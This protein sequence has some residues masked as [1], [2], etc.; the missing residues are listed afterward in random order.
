VS[1]VEDL[2][3]KE[4]QGWHLTGCIGSGADGIVY[5]GRKEGTEAAVKIFFPESLAKNGLA[6]ARERLELQLALIGKKHHPNLVE[7]FEG[8]EFQALGTL[9]L[10]M[11]LVPG[12][13][14]DKLIVG[15]S[16]PR[17]LVR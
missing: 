15:R 7:V 16:L 10:A 11:E 5:A 13:S 8:G 9:Y 4:V 6:S 1:A 14:L 17:R 3:G 2:V 12:T